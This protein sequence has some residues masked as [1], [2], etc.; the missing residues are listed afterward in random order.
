MKLHKAVMILSNFFDSMTHLI[1]FKT[2]KY[3][4]LDQRE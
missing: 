1:F 3:F 4:L 2:K